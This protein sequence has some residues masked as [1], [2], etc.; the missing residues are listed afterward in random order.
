MKQIF[1][2]LVVLAIAIPFIYMA[3]DVTI[4]IIRRT[5]R[6]A[7]PILVTIISNITGLLK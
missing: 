2:A 1:Q 3:F 6:K 4:D 5:S 7:K